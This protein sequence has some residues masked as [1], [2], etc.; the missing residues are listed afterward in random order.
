MDAKSKRNFILLGHAQ[1]GKTTLAESMLYLCKATNRRGT[2]AE[3]TTASDY[4]F[5]EIARKSSINSSLL[6]CDYKNYRIQ[7]IDAPGYA[8]FFGEATAKLPPIEQR[9]LPMAY[10][11]LSQ[12]APLILEHQSKGTIAA[13][14]VNKQNPEMQVQLGFGEE[15]VLCVKTFHASCL[16][17]PRHFWLKDTA[18]AAAQSRRGDAPAAG[19]RPPPG[20]LRGELPS[21]WLPP[22]R[23]TAGRGPGHSTPG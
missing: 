18:S 19:G 17:P 21:A 15:V 6:F 10:A 12:L 11:T 4:S 14:S 8:D 16:V 13:A 5:D 1:S 23:A 22:N 7:M 3:G 20:V 9:P 2:V